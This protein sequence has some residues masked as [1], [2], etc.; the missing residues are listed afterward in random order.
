MR[1]ITLLIAS[2]ALL[3]IGV[4]LTVAT[5]RTNETT[6]DGKFG[7]GRITAAIAVL[8]DAAGVVGI[9]VAIAL[10]LSR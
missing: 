5:S 8:I 2:L 6:I 10:L 1:P 4:V 9:G 7:A 3:G